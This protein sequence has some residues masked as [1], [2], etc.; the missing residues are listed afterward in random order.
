MTQLA[1]SLSKKKA[2]ILTDTLAIKENSLDIQGKA[3]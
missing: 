1:I 3:A 2:R